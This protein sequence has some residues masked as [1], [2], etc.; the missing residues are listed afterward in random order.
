[1]IQYSKNNINYRIIILVI[2][3]IIFAN[4]SKGKSVNFDNI[5]NDS[6]NTWLEN[7][8][9]LK[10]SFVKR[11][12]V[13]IRALNF[14]QL[15]S[16]DS[17]NRQNLFKVAS[18]FY[19]INDFK[20]YKK[21]IDITYDRCL[22]KKDLPGLINSY[23]LFGT[24]FENISQNDSAYYYYLKAEKKCELLNDEKNLCRIY[25]GQGRVRYFINDY[26]GSE[27]NLIKSLKLAKKL[28]SSEFK[29]KAYTM[30]A[31]VSY[32][33]KDYQKAIQYNKRALEIAKENNNDKRMSLSL[34]L[35]NLGVIYTALNQK[36]KAIK[37]FTTALQE[38]NII[39]KDP[40]TYS[41]L[42]DNLAYTKFK[43]KN[44]S[45]LTELYFRASKIR[46]SLH[47][48]QGKN[49]NKLYLS[50]YYAAIK[51]T[52]N[53]IRNAHQAYELSKSFKAPNDML[54][55]LKQ[56][57]KIEPKNALKYA[58]NYIQISDSI[59]QLERETRNKFAKIAYETEELTNEKNIA[60]TQTWI[61]SGIAII[62]FIFGFLLFVIFTQRG[63]HKELQFVHQQQQSNEEIYQLMQTQHFK[64]EEG[65]QIEKN[66]IARDLH[67]GIMN[68]LSSTRFNLQLLTKKSDTESL[69]KCLPY[70]DG[71]H[72][73]EKEIRNIAHDLNKEVFSE[74][75]SFKNTLLS[76]FE[77]QK[78][79]SEAK[80][81]VEL[82]NSINWDLLKGSQ[83]VNVFRMF[84]ELVQNMNKHS[85][86]KNVI[87]TSA[88]RQSILFLEVYDDGVGFMLNEKKKG[89][90]LQNIYARVKECHGTI[91][92]L[93]NTGR[94]TKIII[95]IPIQKE[96]KTV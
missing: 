3:A 13:N 8:E 35:S 43:Q 24:Y 85:N 91:K 87:I 18:A 92:I 26:L 28:N 50:E 30:I 79:L 61:S 53:A 55:C 39:T 96:I 84:Q 27:S 17:L 48:D 34:I 29:Y 23:L 4:C 74:N 81:H 51:D 40:Q 52:A 6:L 10:L 5:R 58:A 56:L 12:N 11:K 83:K 31:T 69:E 80:W 75:E 70:I 64:I 42:L 73:I 20:N 67:D 54:L 60:V 68:K 19:S 89:I 71:I 7:A 77:D 76:F 36:N 45:G 14:L 16:N 88:L 37:L 41:Y 15:Q 57:S 1:M 46:D 66:R 94:G 9:D 59:H 82:D 63:K 47:I 25:Y 38:K 95:K 86:A 32:D 44:Y 72:E 22:K 21:S 93:S 62:V 90:G 2:L 65:R 33:L 49:F 78:A